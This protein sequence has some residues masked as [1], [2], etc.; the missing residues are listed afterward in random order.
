MPE[1]EVDD[2]GLPID[3]PVE[4]NDKE[5]QSDD[6]KEGGEGTEDTDPETFKIGDKEYT[7]E[8]IEEMD[9]NSESYKELLP[10]FTVKSQRLSELEKKGQEKAEESPE[11][12][13][14]LKKGWKP[15]D[16]DELQD[17]LRD[18]RAS[19]SKEA[20][21]I[22][23]KVK[24]D[25]EAARGKVDNFISATKQ[26]DKEFDEEDFY[27][28]AQKHRFPLTSIES[29]K[30]IY[31]SYKEKREAGG[32]AAKKAKEN[33]L[34]RKEETIAGPKGGTKGGFHIDMGELRKSGSAVEAIQN[35]LDKNK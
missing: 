10:E 5:I 35:A 28:Y 6:D 31:S 16:Y 3:P 15:K 21:R 11:E 24:T 18:A 17:A 20:L 34:K 30:S 1:P 7:A 19:G 32:E 26:I 2:Q 22:I 12:P 29:L 33:L 14:Y 4:D 25:E 9:K 23:E 27:E 13:F 8:Q